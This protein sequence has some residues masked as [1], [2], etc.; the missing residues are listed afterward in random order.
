MIDELH[1]RINAEERSRL[2]D[3]L[4]ATQWDLRRDD[5]PGSLRHRLF[6]GE[7]PIAALERYDR[8]G[9]AC[10]AECRSPF[11]DRRVVEFFLQ[12]PARQ[13]VAG[14]W[15]K[16]V[17]RRSMTDRLPAE[18]I[19]NHRGHHLG[20]VFNAA[21]LDADPAAYVRDISSDHPLL[22][23]IDVTRLLNDATPG[24]NSEL[25]QSVLQLGLWLEGHPV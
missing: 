6:G 5:G 18:T 22:A 4:N 15:T 8:S 1:L 17:L 7:Y 13:L 25:L 12:L 3:R 16:S 10:S 20:S 23:Y 14:G 2:H 19:W 9:A 24:L 21:W 11:M